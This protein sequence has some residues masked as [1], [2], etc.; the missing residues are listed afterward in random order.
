MA[1][2]QLGVVTGRVLNENGD[3]LMELS[4]ELLKVDV[5]NGKWRV[6]EHAAASTDDRGL[7]RLWHVTPGLYY[8]KVLGRSSMQYGIGEMPSI[9]PGNL[10]YGPEFYPFGTTLKEAQRIRLEP[11]GLMQADFVLHGKRGYAI[12]GQIHGAPPDTE[13]SLLLLRGGEVTGHDLRL[14]HSSGVFEFIGV[15]PGE[16]VLIAR[17]DSEPARFARVPV[18][19][20]EKDL[21]GVAVRLQ[22][23]AQVDFTFKNRTPR[24]RLSSVMLLA[25]DEWAGA[26][27]EFSGQSEI[28]S[29]LLR[30]EGVPPGRYR[31]QWKG[32]LPAA[33]L[34]SGTADLFQ[35]PL[36]VTESGCEPVEVMIAEPGRLEVEVTGLAN[37]QAATVLA[38]RDDF[39]LAPYST[40]YSIDG[41][42][43]EF[44]SLAPARY[45]IFAFPP[46]T[47][48]AFNEPGVIRSVAD[49]SAVVEVRA[50]ATERVAVK[51]LK[52]PEGVQER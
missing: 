35:E 37:G 18:T 38:V 42:T 17:T 39:P 51:L 9:W 12:R 32:P 27:M 8:L 5:E 21:A 16:Y 46:G 45:R 14:D 25:E 44:H 48:F 24:G 19:V 10:S 3:P 1:L 22:P 34:R 33:S 20:G 13:V 47:P 40:S 31:V 29:G 11:G 2:V 50:G 15:A 7:Y 28:D 41:R 26:G 6:S 23:G 43:A 4:V 30:I 49:Q 36:I 52:L